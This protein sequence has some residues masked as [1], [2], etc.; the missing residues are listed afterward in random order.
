MTS[1]QRDEE[2]WRITEYIDSVIHLD[3]YKEENISD[4]DLYMLIVH[5]NTAVGELNDLTRK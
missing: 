5:L 2:I 4:H 3:V 1:Q